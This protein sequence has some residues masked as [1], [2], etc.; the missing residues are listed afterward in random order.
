MCGPQWIGFC[1]EMFK[2]F[3][4]QLGAGETRAQKNSVPERAV[5]RP[6]KDAH[7][8]RGLQARRLRLK[9]APCSAVRARPGNLVIPKKKV[10]CPR[11]RPA[12][13]AA[14]DWGPPREG[15]ELA[16]VPSTSAPRP[17]PAASVCH[18]VSGR[19]LR[20]PGWGAGA[21]PGYTW[22]AALLSCLKRLPR[23]LQPGLNFTHPSKRPL[24]Q[25]GVG[26]G[27]GIS[28]TA[29][30]RGP[31]EPRGRCSAPGAGFQVS[32]RECSTRNNSLVPVFSSLFILL[33][34]LL[35]EG[36]CCFSPGNVALTYLQ[37]KLHK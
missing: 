26:G 25:G 7:F 24:G 35:V 9:G 29:R 23:G 11:R 16:R 18:L 21:L 27:G 3:V 1:A 4:V 28:L 13:R 8:M 14:G 12:P 20:S 17:S 5:R 22:E 34:F 32:I 33:P 6:G 36:P 10:L 31:G 2:W 19:S 15:R 37:Q 30:E